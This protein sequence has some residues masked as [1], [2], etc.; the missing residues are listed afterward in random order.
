MIIPFVKLLFLLGET[1]PAIPEPAPVS[2]ESTSPCERM[3][4]DGA[5]YT[6]CS[7]DRDEP[8]L[9]LFLNDDTGAPYGEFDA[10]ATSLEAQDETLVFAMNAGMYHEDRSRRSLYRRRKSACLTSNGHRLWQFSPSAQRRLLSERRHC[11]CAG[12]IKLSDTR[13][14]A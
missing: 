11:P 14:S 4:Y 3:R 2:S 12:N 7:F 13:S 1:T 8:R 9:R 10:I 5:S 6:V